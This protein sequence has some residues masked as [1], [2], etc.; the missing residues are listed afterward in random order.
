[1]A[2]IAAGFLSKLSQTYRN[3]YIVALFF[4]SFLI[5]SSSIF[6][7]FYRLR[8]NFSAIARM[9]MS[10][11]MMFFIISSEIIRAPHFS[12]GRKKGRPREEC[13]FLP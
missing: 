4:D 6:R 2:V 13:S 9:M 11:M 12:G 3:P 1:M 5:I 7:F 10:R 8:K